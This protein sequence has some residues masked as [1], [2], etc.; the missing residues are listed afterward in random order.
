MDT[1]SC[2]PKCQ[3][4]NSPQS[5]VVHKRPDTLRR[6]AADSRSGAHESRIGMQLRERATGADAARIARAAGA[7]NTTA[8]ATLMPPRRA[9]WPHALRID[10]ASKTSAAG[11]ING[12]TL[13]TRKP[14]A[15]SNSTTIDTS[16]GGRVPLRR[17]SAA[18][19]AS[20]A[21]IETHMI[22]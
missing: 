10:G 16:T 1:R 13:D 21:T 5:N 12:A 19:I 9:A 8:P 22:G 6:A 20:G 2:G 11:A 4:A 17:A 15:I 7:A 3:I 14:A 18:A